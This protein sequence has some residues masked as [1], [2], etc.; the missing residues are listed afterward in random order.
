[1]LPSQHKNTWTFTVTQAHVSIQ[2][3]RSLFLVV[4][5]KVMPTEYL[6]SHKTY[7]PTLL[8]FYLKF[9]HTSISSLK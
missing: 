4:P 5:I 6:L 7:V 8:S 3:G 9:H 1:M 2:Y